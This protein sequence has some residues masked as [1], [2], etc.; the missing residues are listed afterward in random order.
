MNIQTLEKWKLELESQISNLQDSNISL[1]KT[2]KAIKDQLE[3]NVT[4]IKSL[5]DKVL[6]V[7]K[8]M[9]DIETVK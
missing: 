6:L 8:F 9:E 5:H 2:M 3:T 7:D 4:I 1:Q